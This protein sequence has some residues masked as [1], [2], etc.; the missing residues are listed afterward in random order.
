[1]E[2]NECKSCCCKCKNQV[3]IYKHPS[4]TGEAKGSISEIFGYGCD[5]LKQM[6]EGGIIFSDV[7]HGECELFDDKTKLK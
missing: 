1:M 6:G 5:V 7:I 3:I 2:N 4:N